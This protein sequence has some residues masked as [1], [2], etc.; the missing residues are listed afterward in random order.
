MET[1]RRL[2][3]R[4]LLLKGSQGV[5]MVRLRPYPGIDVTFRAFH[6]VAVRWSQLKCGTELGGVGGY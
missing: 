5:Q 3:Y 1:G 4:G 6:W 2:R